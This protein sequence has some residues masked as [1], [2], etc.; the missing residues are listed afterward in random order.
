M[1]AMPPRHR[2][3]LAAV[4]L[5]GAL[6]LAGCAAS[7]PAPTPSDGDTQTVAEAC[8]TVRAGVEDA[9][10]QLQ[11]LAP[12]DPRAAVDAL[13]GVAERLGAAAGTVGNHE[14]AALLPPLQTG[15]ASA[16]DTSRRSR[17]GICPVSRPCRAP[18]TTSG[19]HWP[20][21]PGSAPGA[22]RTSL[23]ERLCRAGRTIPYH[24][25][26]R[27]RRTRGCCK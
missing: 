3:P 19:R 12:G 9:A 17:A 6:A 21:S 14:V 16:S 18:P 25:R 10:P 15:F 24:R 13:G 2:A 23:D 11:T 27:P 7:S 20:R 5:A 1:T 26:A 4:I 8:D 22:E